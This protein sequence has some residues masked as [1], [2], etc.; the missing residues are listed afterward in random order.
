MPSCSPWNT[1][2]DGFFLSMVSEAS[3]G[4]TLKTQSFPNMSPDKRQLWRAPSGAAGVSRD[5]CSLSQYFSSF[6]FFLRPVE[7]RQ[8]GGRREHCNTPFFQLKENVSKAAKSPFTPQ[9][10]RQLSGLMPLEAWALARNVA[11]TSLSACQGEALSKNP[12]QRLQTPGKSQELPGIR[13]RRS[14]ASLPERC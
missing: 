7:T 9:S 13:H 6:F 3:I 4:L 5:K 14:P 1:F 10:S 2:R 12:S 8:G 11:E